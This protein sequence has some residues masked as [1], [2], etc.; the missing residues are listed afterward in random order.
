MPDIP[1]PP[2]DLKAAG[3][4]LWASITTTYELRPDESALLAAACRTVDELL[5]LEAA[6]RDAPPLVAGSKGQQVAHPLLSEV[7]AHRATLAKLVAQLGIQDSDAATVGKAKS[8][9]GRKL[10]RLRWTG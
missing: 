6:L 7:R 3:K 9:M 8:D 5:H 4:R 10:A 1:K 2:P